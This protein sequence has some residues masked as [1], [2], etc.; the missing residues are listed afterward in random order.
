MESKKSLQS[1]K[2]DGLNK[3]W[4]SYDD[5]CFLY[6]KVS[7]KNIWKLRKKRKLRV[8]K[9][10]FNEKE[11]IYNRADIERIIHENTISCKEEIHEQ[12]NLQSINKI[13]L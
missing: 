7:K 2:N 10:P 1:I 4:L 9:H 13:T 8:S 3:E 11:Y 6:G 12:I 5:I